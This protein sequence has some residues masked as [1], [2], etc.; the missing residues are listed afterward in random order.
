MRNLRPTC[1]Q[2]AKVVKNEVPSVKQ[3]IKEGRKVYITFAPSWVGWFDCSFAQL[4][5]A[6]KKIGFAGVE[7]TAIGA[8]EVSREYASLMQNGYMNRIIATACSSVVMLVERHFPEL[9]KMLASISSNL[10]TKASNVPNTVDS[11]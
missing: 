3:L 11:L 4:G 8:A 6:L 2:G 10:W 7:E 1:P 5:A 9:I